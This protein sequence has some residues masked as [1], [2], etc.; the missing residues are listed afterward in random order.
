MPVLGLEPGSS[1]LES[2]LLHVYTLIVLQCFKICVKPRTKEN[3]QKMRGVILLR[4]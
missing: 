1:A 3:V 2:G 4:N